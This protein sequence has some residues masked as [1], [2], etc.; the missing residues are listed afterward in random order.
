MNYQP[1]IHPPDKKSRKQT[2]FGQVT[3]GMDVVN[4]IRRRDPNQSPT[5]TGDVIESVTIMEKIAVKT[6]TAFLILCEG[7]SCLDISAH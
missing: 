6:A 1:E 2:A 7:F 3:S 4:A 5:Y